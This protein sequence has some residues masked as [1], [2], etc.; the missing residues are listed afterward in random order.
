MRRWLL[1]R[2]L[3]RLFALTI[4]LGLAIIAYGY[5]EAVRDPIARKA[6]IIVAAW[7][8]N[9]PPLRIILLGDTQMA[10][11]IPIVGKYHYR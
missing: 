1:G 10:G 11:D 9:S 2:W 5:Y 6:D 8:E 4:C 3:L 7:P